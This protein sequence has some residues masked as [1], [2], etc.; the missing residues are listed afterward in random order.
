MRRA[1]TLARRG[2]G[3]TAPNPMVGAVVVQGDAI[4]GEGWHARFGEAHAEVAA[5]QAARSRAAGATIYVSLEPC[6]HHGKT[7]P[8]AEALIAAGVTRVVIAIRDPNPAA[9][10]GIE[11]L[12]AAGIP[13]TVGVEESAARE[14]NAAFFHSFSSPLPW[15]TLKLAMSLDGAVADAAARSQWITG[16]RARRETHRLRAGSDA[17]AVGIG[18]VLADDPELTVRH[19]DAP[20]VPPVRVVFDRQARLPLESRLA[21]SARDLRTI[22]VAHDPDPERARRLHDLGVTIVNAPSLHAAL[23]KLRAA[24][25]R[26]LFV[27]GGAR[28]AG[29]LL[30]ESLVNRLIIFQAP[31][32]LGAGA[33]GAFAFAPGVS[34]EEAPRLPVIQRRTLGHDTMTTYAISES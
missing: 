10:G 34:A 6:A 2:W 20:R 24:H 25:L 4:V 3:Q 13:V 15:V 7:P 30:A 21:R 16:P 12:E 32:V 18:T 11:R 31:V 17:V 8:C 9:T 33:L 1:L 29:A 27:E 26:S 23:G 5:L 22:V 14:L 28:L 19:A